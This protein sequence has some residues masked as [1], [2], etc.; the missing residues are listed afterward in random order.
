MQGHLKENANFWS[1]ELEASNFVLGI[2]NEGYRLPFFT[3]PDPIFQF[4]HRSAIDNASFVEASIAELLRDRCIV[5]GD[6]CPTVCSPLQ[7]VSSARGKR[8][9]V[10]D[11]RY[12]NQFLWKD[13]FKYEG[14][15]LVPQMFKR[16]E[17][18]FTFD[19]KSG[20]HHVDINGVF[21]TY[22]GFSW[23]SGSSRRWFK[24]RVLPFG[25]ATA[26]YVFT[27]L[28]RPLVKHWRAKG[29]R[30]I[31]YID[32]GICVASSFTE[33]TKARDMIIGDLKRAGFVLNLPKSH[34]DPVQIGEWLGF[35]ID[36]AKGSFVLPSDKI[37]K[38]QNAIHSIPSS[39]MCPVRAVASV[40]G[41]IIAMSLAIGPVSRLHTRALYRVINQRWSWS[42]PVMLSEEAQEELQFW[43]D[44][45]HSLNGRPIW[46][47]P[48]ATRVAF[49]DASCYGGY[50]VELGSDI[51]NGQW[52]PVEAR[53][54]STWRE[55]K[56][57]DQVLRSFAEKLAGHR[58][59][60]FTDNQ[61]VVRI[62]QLGSRRQHLQDGAMSIFEVCLANNI[63]LDIAWIPR[64][65]NDR[66]D[67][68]S[69]I[70]DYDDWQLCPRIFHQ[71]DDMWG[72]HTIDRFASCYN[73]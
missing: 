66:A 45:M 69:R 33:T 16:G 68:I 70:V 21:W 48:G 55:L 4:N 19:L 39:A 5:E 3:T 22:L 34:L 35:I 65:L 37:T 50:V 44:H 61:N 54:S 56:A 23:G 49:S 24:F 63:R 15:D 17:Y 47:S 10:I 32:D 58:V 41:Q 42:A 25:L 46:F 28:L 57:V 72:P 8:R 20:Y 27:K 1:E 38:L 36:L 59:K 9:L 6:D 31:V 14:L 53:Q 67:F 7:V 18:F 51:A 73:S 12:V 2:V 62:V 60:W 71:L 43:Q 11:L 64:S 40:V 29:L 13:K 30:A 52:S 26:C